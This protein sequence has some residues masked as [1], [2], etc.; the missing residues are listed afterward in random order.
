MTEFLPLII[1]LASGAAAS[2]V[3]T[4]RRQRQQQARDTFLRPAE[5]FSRAAYVARSLAR[6]VKPPLPQELGRHRNEHL[7]SDSVERARRFALCWEALDAL[8]SERGL[9]ALVYHPRSVAAGKAASV[10]GA[11]R[12]MVETSEA[13]YH[14]CAERAGA[15]C[16]ALRQKADDDYGVTPRTGWTSGSKSLRRTCGVAWASPHGN[17]FRPYPARPDVRCSS[18]VGWAVG[19][20]SGPKGLPLSSV[21]AAGPTL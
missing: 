18:P 2:A 13:F 7:V 1:A 5:E 9:I 21:P 15:D 4:G 16:S 8:R 14:D 19:S 20:V 3:I 6:T 10:I 12:G 17:V 11:L